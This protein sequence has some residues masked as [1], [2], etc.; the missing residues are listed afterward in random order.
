MNI[1]LIAS[2]V[3]AGGVLMFSGIQPSY[4]L[5]QGGNW[6][7]AFST[8]FMALF[9]G[10][11]VERVA[12]ETRGNAGDAVQTFYVADPA[13]TDAEVLAIVSDVNRDLSQAEAERKAAVTEALKQRWNDQNISIEGLK[14][15]LEEQK[16]QLE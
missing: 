2:V 11:A 14:Q 12:K 15:R 16:S 3:L 1:K 10:E 13:S 4:L 6:W 9:N 7:Q 5:E 8:D